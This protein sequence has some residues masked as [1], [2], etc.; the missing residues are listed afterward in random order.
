MYID[1][2]N[3][4]TARELQQKKI[5]PINFIIPDLLPEGL[6]GLA[7]SPKAGKSYLAHNIA[8]AVSSGKVVLDRFTTNKCSVLYLPY[9]DNERRL[10]DRMENV[11]DE[12]DENAPDNVI[13]PD[14][15]YFPP[16]NEGGLKTIAKL[17]DQKPDIKLVIIDT[18]ARAIQLSNSKFKNQYLEEYDIAT[19]LQKFAI[20]RRICLLCLHHTTKG[21]ADN[22]FN[23]I[24]GSIGL[25]AGFDT[26]F[27]INK[28]KG[29]Q[30][31]YTTGRD[32][33]SNRFSVEFNEESFKWR[34]L[35]DVTNNVSPERQEIFQLFNNDY[36]KV[37]TSPEI[38]NLLKKKKPAV[39][40]LLSKMYDEGKLTK[41]KTGLYKLAPKQLIV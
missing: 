22:I 41:E 7:G 28:E 18:L 19:Q 37:L 13:Y 34:I 29:K 9:E 30:Y 24:Q 35:D 8:Y 2:I 1:D 14:L 17:L 26:L 12:D 21:E 39:R 11:M 3:F 15:K 31:L 16:L 10:Q 6:A 23:L 27:V 40:R 5:D 32:I 20:E 4:T 33:E 36:Q 25:T 38:A